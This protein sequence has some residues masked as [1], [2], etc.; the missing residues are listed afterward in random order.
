[1]RLLLYFVYCNTESDCEYNTRPFKM[2]SIFLWKGQAII[3]HTAK[4]A[5][6]CDRALRSLGFK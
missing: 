3:V 5:V 2:S 6:A 4:G 1:M